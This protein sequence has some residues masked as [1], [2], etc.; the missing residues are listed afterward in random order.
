MKIVVVGGVAAGLKAAAK[1]RRGDPQA[2]ITVIEKGKLVS[3]GAC[4]MPYYVGGDINDV[5]QLIMTPSGNIRNADFFKKV[6]DIDVLTETLATKINRKEKTVTVTNLQT[7]EISQLEY[8]KLVIATGASHIKPQLPGIDLANIYQMGHPDDA[9]AVRHGLETGKFNNAVIIGAGLIGLEMAEA[10]TNWGVE[11]TVVEMKDQIF[12]AFLDAE[13]AAAV[14]K[15]AIKEGIN[16][17]TQEKVMQFKGDSAVKEVVTD[18][19]TIP[20]DLVILAIGVK[21][22][23]ELASQA[24]LEIGATGAIKVNEYLETSDPDIYAGG[25]CV[26]NI[27][28]VSGESV[29]A[30]MGSTANKHGRVIGENICGASVKFRGVLNTVVVKLMELNVGKVGLTEREAKLKGYEYITA[31]ISGFD[32]PHY[33]PAA[34]TLTLKLIVDVKERRILGAQAFGEGDI[35]KR[36][37]VIATVLTFGGTVDDLFDI[38]L[39]YAPPYNGP[40]DNAAVAANVVMNKLTG[41]MAGISVLAAK[42]RMDSGN[43]VFLDVRAPEELK[44]IRIGN[45]RGLKNIPL[46]Q[47]RSRADEVDKDSEIV[48]ICKIGLR[49]YEASLILRGQGFE[50]VKVLEGGILAWPFECDADVPK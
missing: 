44:K 2:K 24:G 21:P 30:P 4:G 36:I 32:R 47:L 50:D 25:D 46:G 17:I 5:K 35:T 1:I 23:V 41:R 14:A 45:C 8:D 48:A 20:A 19:R 3:Y 31:T 34:K 16:I 12:P 37:D 22:N 40:I 33:M 26:E 9:E 43:T 27:N 42:E 11:V 6:K 28:I 13:T 7:N 38:D 10:L 15:Y 29:F 18:K 49:G 39:S